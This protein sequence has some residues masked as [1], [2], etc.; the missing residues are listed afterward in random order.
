MDRNTLIPLGA[1][2]NK[3]DTNAYQVISE[4]VS[5]FTF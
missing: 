3:N 5:M 4:A 1:D 2:K